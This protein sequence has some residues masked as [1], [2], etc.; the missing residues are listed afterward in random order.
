MQQYLFFD[1]LLKLVTLAFLFS[2]S[3]CLADKSATSKNLKV[4]DAAEL[5]TK[6]EILWTTTAEGRG[7]ESHGH[8]LISCSD[9]GFLQ[10]GETGSLPDDAQ[11]FVAK[12]SADGTITWKGE[13]SSPG[14]NLGNGAMEVDDGYIVFGA[15]NQDSALIKVDKTIGNV[16]FSK[17]FDFGGVD[18]IESVVQVGSDLI[19]VG[20][21]NAQDPDTTFFAEG[22]GHLMRFDSEGNLSSD[23][24]L[25]DHM[26]HAY[27]IFSY[28]EDLIVG[29]LTKD[30]EDYSL[31]KL[32]KVG[33]TIW[34]KT[35][36]GNNSDHLFA[37]DMD[38]DGSI[39]LSGHTL[40]GTDNW[41]TYTVKVN[42]L[43][44]II[45]ERKVGNPR[46]F[47]PE[48]IH[49]EAWGIKATKDGGALVV[50]GTGDEYESYSEC[51]DQDC[52]DRWHA[53]LVRLGGDG[54]ILWEKT[55]P[56][57]EDGDWA[58]EDIVLTKDGGALMAVD[59]GQFTFVRLLSID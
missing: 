33:E 20:Y 50:A 29:G 38:L 46:G 32:S 43:G 36:G 30:A 31:I 15:M 52:S 5:F 11:I 8:F 57:P 26:S 16:I 37:M 1:K 55:Y 28:Q 21:T 27:R 24:S 53:Y 9:G 45:W 39:F 54:Q 41:D 19:A 22:K 4:N 49:D 34:S 44:E 35:Y 13:Y 6:P 25:N 14:H 17:N 3:A 12:V 51:N 10:I 2:L 18:A 42:Q 23:S 58:G 47:D 59:D 40:S 7:E 56:N 48:Y